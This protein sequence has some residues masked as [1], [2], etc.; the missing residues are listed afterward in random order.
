MRLD[1]SAE[2]VLERTGRAKV[3]VPRI[4]DEKSDGIELV[5]VT[6]AALPDIPEVFCGLA[7]SCPA[8]PGENP[9]PATRVGSSGPG[10]G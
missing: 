4:L 7:P 2:P 8:R 10:E 6:I 1:D 3:L 9:A 5:V